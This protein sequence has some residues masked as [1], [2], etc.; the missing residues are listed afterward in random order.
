MTNSNDNIESKLRKLQQSVYLNIRFQILTIKFNPNIEDVDLIP[1]SYAF[2]WSRHIYPC[3]NDDSI[4]HENFSECF[5]VPK[6]VVTKIYQIIEDGNIN[7]MHNSYRELLDKID[8][9][10]H[11]LLPYVLRYFFLCHKLNSEVISKLFRDSDDKMTDLTDEFNIS[12]H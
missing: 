10:F 11:D 1:D 8:E 9:R 3:F 5:L 6:Y 7:K 12:E 4:M 2:A